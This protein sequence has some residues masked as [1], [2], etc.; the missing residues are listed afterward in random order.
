[1]LSRSIA[2]RGCPGSA[3]SLARSTQYDWCEYGA[4]K[5]A[6]IVSAMHA[7]SISD[8]FMIATDA[9]SA[10]VRV[11]GGTINW[12]VF[13]FIS[14][15]G[16][17]FFRAVRR[18]D[19]ASIGALLQGFR[20]HLLSDASSIYNGLHL[21][22]ILELA[23]WAHVRRYFWKATLTEST[24]AY[25]ALSIISTLFKVVAESNRISK[26]SERD[27]FRVKHATPIV[28][29]FDA[30]MKQARTRGG[31]TRPDRNSAELRDQPP[32]CASSVPRRSAPEVA[33]QRLGARA[34]IV[35]ERARQL[36]AL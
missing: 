12:H 6:P 26:L 4:L 15:V 18:H 34:A 31:A 17:I 35:E 16:H 32:R 19:G 21:V 30:W 33:Q 24:L 7:E 14:D 3:D 2:R 5:L 29:T 25:E 22:G 11:S 20:G 1:M 13:V 23:C 8:S 10:P 28:D 36:D 9:T 27:A